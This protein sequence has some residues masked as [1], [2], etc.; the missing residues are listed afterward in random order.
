MLLRSLVL[1][2]IAGQSLEPHAGSIGVELAF[3]RLLE[4]HLPAVW[5]NVA[6]IDRIGG[7]VRMQGCNQSLDVRAI[8][9]VHGRQEVAEGLG[10]AIARETGN[11]R[12]V[13]AAMG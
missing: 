4:P 3:S 7:A 9:R 13:L 8:V 12:G 5:T 1:G 2:N 11:F 6:K 10:L